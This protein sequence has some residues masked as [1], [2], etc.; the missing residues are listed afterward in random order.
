MRRTVFCARCSATRTL[1]QGLAGSGYLTCFRCGG[2]NFL[3]DRAK[4]LAVIPDGSFV[5]TASDRQF[6][7]AM[8]IA[9]GSLPVPVQE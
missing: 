9:R 7:R 2:V 1:G 5:V 3:N 4:C 6:L 8:R